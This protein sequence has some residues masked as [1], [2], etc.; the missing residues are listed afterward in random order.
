MEIRLVTTDDAENLLKI[1][2][3]YVLNTAISF[4]YQVPDIKEFK[5]RIKTTLE[6]YPYYAA[7]INERIV[8]YAY[9]G[10]F[11]GREAY[12]FSAELTVY[13]DK[14]YKRQGI[15][16]LLYENLENK[17]KDAGIT[18]LYACIGTPD[19]EDEYLSFDSVKFHEHMGFKLA[20]EFHKCGYKFN[21]WYNM[22]WMEKIIKDCS[23]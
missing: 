7:L 5:R 13:I 17:L 16:K 18:N 8:G 15:G 11:V 4:E 3:Y 19:K 1:Y 20:G 23:A 12:R 10:P 2:E 22:V 9:A 6:K 21:R 14:D